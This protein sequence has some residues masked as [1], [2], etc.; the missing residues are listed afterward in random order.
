MSEKKADGMDKDSADKQAEELAASIF[1][2]LEATYGEQTIM[3]VLLPEWL[4]CGELGNQFLNNIQFTKPED[5]T[6]FSV[7]NDSYLDWLNTYGGG[8]IK[9]INETTQKIVQQIISDGLVNGDSTAKIADALMEKIGEYS[10]ARA[11]KIALTEVHNSA[12]TGNYMTASASGFQWKTWVSAADNKVRESHRR[13]NGTRIEIDKEF[14]AGL[15]FPGDSRADASEVV[16]CR[17]ILYYE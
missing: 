6:L 8:Q 9:N 16:F 12:L 4:N 3:E 13:L 15:Y 1:T 7:I 11:T 17:C 14:K 10:E 5:G 2:M